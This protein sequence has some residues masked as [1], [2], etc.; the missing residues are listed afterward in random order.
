[1][2]PYMSAGRA[3]RRIDPSARRNKRESDEGLT[4]PADEFLDRHRLAATDFS[5]TVVRAGKDAV[6][7]VDGDFMKVLHQACFRRAAGK[8]AL[9]SKRVREHTRDIQVFCRERENRG[10][11]GGAP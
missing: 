2:A 3:L 9:R 7:V 10:L 5:Y 11:R 4:I 8:C 6:A 1:M